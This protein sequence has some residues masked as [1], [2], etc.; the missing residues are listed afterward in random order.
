M[1]VLQ[2]ETSQVYQVAHRNE[3]HTKDNLT[4]LARVT[5]AYTQ[6]LLIFVFSIWR[7]RMFCLSLQKNRTFQ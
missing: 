5:D 3:E 7:L 6:L 2:L 1:A 4:A